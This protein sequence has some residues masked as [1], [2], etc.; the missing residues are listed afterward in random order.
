MK[1]FYGGI[2]SWDSR[3]AVCPVALVNFHILWRVVALVWVS[4]EDAKARIK[5]QVVDRGNTG[6]GSGKRD[7][8]VKGKSL[9]S[10]SS[11]SCH[12]G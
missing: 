10:V 2:N 6:R 4:S 3:I 1:F 8:S 9:M 7:R 11:S 5:V 12:A